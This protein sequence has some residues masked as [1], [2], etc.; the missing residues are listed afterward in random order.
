MKLNGSLVFDASSAS[1]IQN[2]R[3]QKYANYAAVPAYTSADVGRLVFVTDTATMYFGSGVSGNWITMATGGDATALQNEVNALETTLGALVN[4]SGVFQVGAV[5]GPA[6]SGSEADVTELLQALSNYANANNTLAELD[7]VALVSAANKDF[8]MY[9]GA[10]WVDHVLVAADLTDV[11]STAAELNILDGATLTVTELNYVDGVTSGIQDQLDNKQALDAG[12][13]ALAAFNTNGIIVQTADNTFAGRSLTAPAAGITITNPDGVSGSPTFA[14]ANDL[15]AVEALATTGYIVRTGDGTATTRTIGGQ[16]GRIVITD[17]D[18]VA[19]NTDID[20][21]TVTNPGDGGSFMKVT[22]DTYGRVTNSTAVVTGDITALVDATYVNVSGDTMSS[23][24][25]LT[26][27]GTGTVTGLPAPVGD[28]DAA[29]KAYVDAIAQGLTWK[30]AVHVM[31]TADVSVSSAPAAIDGF[32]LTAGDRVLLT[33]QSTP[34][35]NGIY[36]FNGAASAMTRALDADAYGELNGAAVFVQEG[37]ASADTGWVQ[38]AALTAFTGQTWSQ[39]SG[40]TLYTWGVGLALTGNTVNVNL[41]SGIFE[42]G[43]D[44]VGIELHDA[45]TGAI[46]LTTDGSDRSASDAS[47][48]H[49]LLDGA[50]ALAQ[51]ASGLKIN[52]ASVTNAMLVNPAIATDS[53]AGTGS[54][55]LGST[56]LVAGTSAQGITTSASGTTVT[57]SAS[58]ATTASKGVASF[59]SGDFDVAAGVVTIKEAGVDN[60][61]LANS[62]VTLTGTSGSDAFALGESVAV[63]GGAGGEV[64][65]A[66]TDNQ[67]AI[68]VRDATASLKGVAS[69]AAADFTV[70]AGD[71]TMVAKALDSLT[72]VATSSVA[73]GQTLVYNG[74]NFV[75]RK[76][77]HTE[78]FT[79]STSW[80]VSHGIGQKFCNVTVIDAADEMVIPQSVTFDS[81]TQLTVT[82]NTAIAGQVAVSGVNA[83][84]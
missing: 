42:Q 23:N 13:T 54:L 27:V 47:K 61:Q 59:D 9:D 24:A 3:V 1:E 39:F 18:G 22:T 83:G 67:V 11:T 30:N 73:A 6:F 14:L 17:G 4:T 43:T 80:V 41:G 38:T 64:S 44:A 36:V 29:N 2:L 32:T 10:A 49:L 21:A 58:D 15:A 55:A 71:V 37:T 31:A 65:T 60:A 66:V 12:L 35:E 75:N 77:F 56:L 46:I 63:V 74:T 52:A 70:T 51:T 84:A 78:A 82:F 33:A 69:F 68:S 25:S 7:D 34:A 48:L 8:L 76:V 20:L 72:D 79:S 5:T 57:I 19:S 28:T 45:A 62:T 16:A 53:D 81:A 40:S 50:G 26:F